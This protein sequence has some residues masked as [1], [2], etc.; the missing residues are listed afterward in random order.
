MTASRCEF[1]RKIMISPCAFDVHII[2]LSSCDF[3]RH[4]ADGDG[5]IG[6]I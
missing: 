4:I 2:M 1:D 5:D 3:D 6:M